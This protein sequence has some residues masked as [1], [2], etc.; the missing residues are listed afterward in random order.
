MGAGSGELG[1]KPHLPESACHQEGWRCQTLSLCSSGW[2]L[3]LL[4]FRRGLAEE[5]QD[6]AKWI[7]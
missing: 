3:H 2:C 6:I 7:E 4:V 5:V 1:P